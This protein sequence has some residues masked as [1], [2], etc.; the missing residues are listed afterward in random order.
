ML[1]QFQVDT[2]WVGHG[3]PTFIIAEAGLNHG[4]DLAL[5]IR[6]IEAAATAGADA[7]KF[8]AFDTDRRFG[9]DEAAKTLVRPA[10]FNELQFEQLVEAAARNRILV[11]STAFDGEKVDMLV[12]LGI[13]AIKIASCDVTNYS[14]LTRA[15]RAGVPVF[16]SRGTA[17]RSDIDSALRIFDGDG[18]RVALLHCVSSYP[19]ADE[20]ANLAA[21]HALRHLYEVP[22]GYSDHTTGLPV[23]VAA[24][25]AGACVLEKHFTLDR[26][27]GGID[28]ELSANPSE[29]ERLVTQVRE[30]ERVLG[31]GRI[32][33]M[34]CESEELAY[35]L[36]SRMSD[37]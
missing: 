37:G 30:A 24:V 26:A 36:K 12:R 6:M 10:E 19:L 15:S 7:I 22:I 8:Q 25:Y 34:S 3:H 35:R 21:I 23:P 32:E 33:A 17:S 29:L 5:A 14:L 9:D 4:G 18:K 31:H 13:Q 20:D 27:L 2:R 1:T 28:A 11:M 16:L